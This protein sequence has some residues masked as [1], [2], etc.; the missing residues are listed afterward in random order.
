MFAGAV[1]HLAEQQATAIAQ[2]RVVGAELM[3]GIHHR[4]RFGF[5]P[6][7]VAAEQFGEHWRFGHGWVEVEQGHG[8]VARHDQ[9]RFVEGLGQDVG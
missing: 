8:G 2:L 4:P 5:G 1:I 9:A 6:Q 3:P 7:L